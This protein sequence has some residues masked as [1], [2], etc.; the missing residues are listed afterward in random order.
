MDC[1]HSV[2]CSAKTASLLHIDLVH[3]CLGR[4]WARVKVRNLHKQ[5]CRWEPG[6]SILDDGRSSPT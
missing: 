1:G 6:I 3:E 2:P 5:L 4:Q